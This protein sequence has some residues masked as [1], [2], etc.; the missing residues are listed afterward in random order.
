L[1]N[2]YSFFRRPPN[3]P[4]AYSPYPQQPA[5]YGAPGTTYYGQTPVYQQQGAVIIPIYRPFWNNLVATTITPGL[6]AFLIISGILYLIWGI[7]AIGL[8]IGLI[9]NLSSTYYR[10][11]WGGGVLIGGGISMLVAAC[12]SSYIMMHLVRLFIVSLVFCIL[13]FILSVVNYTSSSYCSFSW[14]Y[15]DS[16]T[17][18][19][20]KGVLL[21]LFLIATIHT[22]VNLVIASNTHKRT[23]STPASNVPN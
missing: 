6:R 3:G 22:I 8:E 14:L 5:G 19:N 13:G 18:L 16:R 20:I 15:C 7:L 17:E 10:G 1:R 2:N 12:R 21:G 9:I 4:P 23:M 11:F